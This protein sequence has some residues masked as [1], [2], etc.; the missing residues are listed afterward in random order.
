METRICESCKQEYTPKAANQRVCGDV[1]CKAHLK[2]A[3]RKR[4]LLAQKK[5]RAKLKNL[6]PVSRYYIYK[7][8]E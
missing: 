1:L 7:P 2:E 5:K 3:Q 6:G 4:A 8:K